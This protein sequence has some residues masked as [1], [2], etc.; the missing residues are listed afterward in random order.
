MKK[1]KLVIYERGPG[2]KFEKKGRTKQAFKKQCDMTRIIKSLNTG[3][4]TGHVNQRQ[5]IY[6]GIRPTFQQIQNT[7]AD[8][9]TQYEELPEKDK[10]SFG[11][12]GG[13]VE[14]LSEPEPQNEKDIEEEGPLEEKAQ[15][16]ASDAFDTDESPQQKGSE[17]QESA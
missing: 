7:L 3:N 17:V 14:Y 8:A 4:V 16:S 1:Y 10:E 6:A 11:G 15:E 9:R 13:F 2:V 12:F 5:P